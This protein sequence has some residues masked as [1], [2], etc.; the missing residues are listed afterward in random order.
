VDRVR[1]VLRVNTPQLEVHVGR[2]LLD[3][4]PNP[5]VGAHRVRPATLRLPEDRV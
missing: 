2:V 3:S 5:A 1:C 4:L